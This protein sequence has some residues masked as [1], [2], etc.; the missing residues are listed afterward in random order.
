M[1]EIGRVRTTARPGG[2]RAKDSLHSIIEVPEICQAVHG[3]GADSPS[4][5]RLLRRACSLRWAAAV[6][7]EARSG[8]SAQAKALLARALQECP[9]SG[10]LW[11]LAIWAEARPQRGRAEEVRRRP[12]RDLHCRAALLGRTKDRKGSPV[13]RPRRRCGLRYR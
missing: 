8:A 13:V 3:P 9:G 12:A 10:V 6:G 11:S 2:A 4:R 5:E 1:V 7:I